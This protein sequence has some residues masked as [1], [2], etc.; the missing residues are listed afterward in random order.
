MEIVWHKQDDGVDLRIKAY[1]SSCALEIFV[2]NDRRADASDFGEG[3]DVAPWAADEYGCGN[4]QFTPF[5]R[6]RDVKILKKYDITEEQFA[7]IADELAASLSFGKC[8]WCA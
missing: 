7:K 2:I 1:G 3:K 5:A 6:P 4:R 8:S